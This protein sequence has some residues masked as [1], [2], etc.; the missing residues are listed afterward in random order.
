MPGV[1]PALNVRVEQG[2]WPV[3]ELRLVHVAVVLGV[4]SRDSIVG[5]RVKAE[6]R[7]RNRRRK[8]TSGRATASGM[9]G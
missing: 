1:K 2:A 4:G 8:S 9:H 6:C 3:P 7:A 5:H